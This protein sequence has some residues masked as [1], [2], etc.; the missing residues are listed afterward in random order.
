MKL[1]Q[2]LIIALNALSLIRTKT[3]P[4]TAKELSTDLKVSHPFL[5]QI[6]RQL[7]IAGI[8]EVRRGPGGGYIANPETTQ[9]YKVAQAVGGD[10]GTLNSGN[11]PAE[12][13]N[14]LI[15]EAF[16]SAEV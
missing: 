2:R 10:F 13:L 12:T 1:N 15:I 9:A 3:G 7:R 6:L 4:V 5:E 16:M 14:R 11:G 8:V